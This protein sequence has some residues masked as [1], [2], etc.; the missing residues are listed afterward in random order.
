MSFKAVLT[1]EVYYMNLE[2]MKKPI[3]IRFQ[4]KKNISLAG[5]RTHKNDK[6]VQCIIFSISHKMNGLYPL[7]FDK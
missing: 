3:Y 1:S 7:F 4:E 5:A 2:Y 6:F